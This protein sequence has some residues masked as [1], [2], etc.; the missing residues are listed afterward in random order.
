VG[1]DKTEPELL[2]EI[3]RLQALQIRYLFPSQA[4][5]SVALHKAGF[6]ASRIAQLL[7]TT[8]ATVSKDLQRA[9]KR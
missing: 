6:P 8:P 7:G 4:D 9:K 1:R 2:E 3:V 5:A